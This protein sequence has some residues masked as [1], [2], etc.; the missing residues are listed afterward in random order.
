MV[1]AS[2]GIKATLWGLFCFSYLNQESVETTHIRNRGVVVQWSHTHLWAERRL[3]GLAAFIEGRY[4]DLDMH[5]L[6][7]TPIIRRWSP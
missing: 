4:Y 7:I 6:D 5:C 1:L 2:D 3:L